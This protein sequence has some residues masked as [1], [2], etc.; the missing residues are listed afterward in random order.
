MIY[1]YPI[2]GEFVLAR[3]KNVFFGALVI[4]TLMAGAQIYFNPVVGTTEGKGSS[5]DTDFPVVARIKGGMLEVSSVSARRQFTE[6]LS[7]AVWGKAL[8]FC[9]ESGGISAVYK[10]TY[11]VKL[12]EKWPLVFRDN[13]LIAR[14]PELEPSLPVAIDTASI[15]E[16]GT[17]GC[18]FMLDLGT[19]ELALQKITGRL[20]VRALNR[21]TKDF[22]R[23]EARETVIEFLRTWAFSQ[24]DYPEIAPDVEIIVLFPGE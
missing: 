18:W 10:I 14:V 1:I 16:T 11:R 17:T 20:E 21:K 12:E 3:L 6:D 8:P 13:K 22:G 5:A 15:K 2:W 7:P 24:S 19:Q 4:V 23:D 9:K